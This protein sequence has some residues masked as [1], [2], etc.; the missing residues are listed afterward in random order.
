M[1]IN[2]SPTDLRRVTM[3]VNDIK[4]CLEIYHGILGMQIHYDEIVEMQGIALPAGIKGSTN[5]ARLVI[6]K[7]NH[8]YVGMLGI[9]EYQDPPLSGPIPKKERLNIGDCVF[10]SMVE[11]AAKVY[12]Q[13]QHIP[14]VRILSE[15]T[16]HEY[17]N[18]DGAPYTILGFTFFD[19]N[20]YF[21]ECNQWVK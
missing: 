5:R 10:V 21:I 9:L 11:D 3:L 6:L 2:K 16:L 4:P 13:L 15:P 20:S 8:D 19:P 12:N 1:N 7:A 18:K 14:G 17:P